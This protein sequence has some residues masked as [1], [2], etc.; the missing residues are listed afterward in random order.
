ME[1]QQGNNPQ[2]VVYSLLSHLVA[3]SFVSSSCDRTTY[4]K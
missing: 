1:F 2:I 4:V 3:S